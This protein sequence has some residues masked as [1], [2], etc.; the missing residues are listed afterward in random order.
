[1]RR[2]LILLLLVPV[3]ISC[4]MDP[5]LNGGNDTIYYDSADWMGRLPSDTLIRNITMPGT[6]DSCANYDLLGL[7][8]ISSTQDLTLKEQLE[9]GV[10]CLD[11][12][13][14]ERDC[15]Y[16]IYHGPVYMRM[17]LDDVTRV[18]RAFLEKHPTE[19]ILLF[20]QYENG[21]HRL[22]TP[23]IA[24]LRDSDTGLFF[25]GD[26]LDEVRLSDV[27][28]KIIPAESYYHL[29]GE[30]ALV[31]QGDFWVPDDEWGY[32]EE[33]FWVT[34]D[35]QRILDNALTLMEKVRTNNRSYTD[36]PALYSTSSYFSGQFGL[37]NYRIVSSYV[38]PKVQ[39]ELEKY[40]EGAYFGILSVDHITRDLAHAIYSCN[41][42][43]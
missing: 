8:S 7:S 29:Y 11:I 2:L 22:A 4:S 24:E 25:Q 16:G 31:S 6:H 18:C 26:S 36:Y 23:A 19:F 40:S 41:S 13:I 34:D 43:L 42:L 14:T 5:N 27:A 9:A 21:H 32:E 38:N 37:P 39:A 33:E 1:M 3:L 10:R 15:G 17:T 28:G 35:P 20:I 12:R 30:P